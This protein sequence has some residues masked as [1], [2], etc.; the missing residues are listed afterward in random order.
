MDNYDRIRIAVSGGDFTL[1]V[2][3]KS[4]NGLGTK[5]KL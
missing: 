2:A 1:P 5:Q 3:E 4:S